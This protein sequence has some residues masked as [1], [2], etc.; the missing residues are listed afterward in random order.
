[1]YKGW[2]RCLQAQRMESTRQR[3]LGRVTNTCFAGIFVLFVPFSFSQVS[4]FFGFQGC[5]KGSAMLIRGFLK[6]PKQS[7]PK[8]QKTNQ[9]HVPILFYFFFSLP[10]RSH[11]ALSCLAVISW[12]L[13]L[14]EKCLSLPGVTDQTK[15]YWHPNIFLGA[16]TI[17]TSS[18][19]SCYILC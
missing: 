11:L 5:Q 19:L 6:K 15:C 3:N 1:M 4:Q 14:Q 10:L 13:L 18:A 8:K 2:I 7:P 9:N 12:P 16:K 17:P